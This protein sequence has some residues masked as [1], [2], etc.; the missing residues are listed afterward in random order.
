VELEKN[1]TNNDLDHAPNNP[2]CLFSIRSKLFGPIVDLYHR[3]DCL[4]DLLGF[5]LLAVPHFQAEGRSREGG[6]LYQND[7]AC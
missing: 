4:G 3:V 5:C 1:N 7:K 2:I 6:E